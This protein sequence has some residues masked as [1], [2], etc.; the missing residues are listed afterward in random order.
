MAVI[1]NASSESLRSDEYFYFDQPVYVQLIGDYYSVDVH[2]VKTNLKFPLSFPC[3]LDDEELDGCYL[4][5]EY[6]LRKVVFSLGMDLLDNHVKILKLPQKAGREFIKLIEEENLET[7]ST[8]FVIIRDPAPSYKYSFRIDDR[9]L[10]PK[11]CEDRDMGVLLDKW[12]TP[13]HQK[14]LVP[15]FNKIMRPKKKPYTRSEDDRDDCFYEL[16]DSGV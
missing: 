10:D 4:C 5:W 15:N 16:E 7:S 14:Q 12:M 9:D 6:P 2:N 13:D 1:K 11:V 8:S 3:G